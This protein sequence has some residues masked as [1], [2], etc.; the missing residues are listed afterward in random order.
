MWKK[1]VEYEVEYQV[2]DE[3]MGKDLLLIEVRVIAHTH[4]GDTIIAASLHIMHQMILHCNAHEI[5]IYITFTLI[6]NT[7]FLTLYH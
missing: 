6:F 1:I 2:E 5:L 3:V 4:C 7:C